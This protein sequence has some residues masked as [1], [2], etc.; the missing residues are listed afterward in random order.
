MNG[1]L[2]L[3]GQYALLLLIFGAGA[4]FTVIYHLRI[5]KAKLKPRPVCSDEHA[6][7]CSVEELF[8][9]IE[10][11]YSLEKTR[12]K[13]AYQQNKEILQQAKKAFN[14]KDTET[15]TRLLENN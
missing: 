13:K 4:F 2:L 6:K 3:L 9:K 1:K 10:K 8:S 15:L 14:A 5:I 7:Q 12:D 11:K